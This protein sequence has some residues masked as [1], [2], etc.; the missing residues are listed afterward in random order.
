[1]RKTWSSSNTESTRAL[2]SRAS[3]SERPNGFS[4]ITRTSAS[5]RSARSCLPR[6]STMTGKNIGAVDR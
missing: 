5:S 2:R 1:M 4:M 6:Q 3:S